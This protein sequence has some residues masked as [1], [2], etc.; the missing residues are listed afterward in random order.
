MYDWPSVATT[1][2]SDVAS[3][4]SPITKSFPAASPGMGARPIV[5]TSSTSTI[6]WI[7]LVLRFVGA[8]RPAGPQPRDGLQRAPPVSRRVASQRR[9]RRVAQPVAEQ[10]EPQHRDEDGEPGERRDPPGRGQELPALDDHVAPARQRRPGAEP[11]IAQ[12]R[13]DQDR[14][15]QQQT[16]LDDHDGQ[17]VPEQVARENARVAGAERGGRVDEIAVAKAQ[18]LATHDAPDRRPGDERDDQRG[19]G[20]ARAEER[21]DDEDQE[22]R[23][24]RKKDV[25]GAHDRRVGGSAEIARDASD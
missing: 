7:T 15:A 21:D 1:G 4:L 24:N 22:Q 3:P 6:A 11:K 9:I 5:A 20:E 2:L 14:L 12:A 13:L 17:R 18:A 23:R 25:G 10:I 16:G 19:I 8:P